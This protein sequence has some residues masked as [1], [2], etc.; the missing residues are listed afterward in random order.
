[1]TTSEAIQHCFSEMKRKDFD[2]DIKY[3][4][5]RQWRFRYNQGKLQ[6]H[7]Q[8]EILI[9]I[10][11]KCEERKIT[12]IIPDK[13]KPKP[14]AVETITIEDKKPEESTMPE[15]AI[16]EICNNSDTN[17]IKK[18]IG[19][20]GNPIARINNHFSYLKRGVHPNKSMQNDYNK[21][22][23]KYFSYS[24]IKWCTYEEGNVI[25]S[26]YIKENKT[27][28]PEYGYNVNKGTS[29]NKSRIF[30]RK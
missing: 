8:E 12:W 5:F 21:F 13:L 20:S 30:P 27:F 24:I 3:G 15:C 6:E 29:F 10:G 14:I 17:K 19:L 23:L 11:Y 9:E 18:Y 26:D 4:T 28:M 22:G 2:D 1:M 7:K 25:E 16:Y